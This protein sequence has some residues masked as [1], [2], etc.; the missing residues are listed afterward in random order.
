MMVSQPEEIVDQLH[1]ALVQF[2]TD[3][4][5]DPDAR[6]EMVAELEAARQRFLADLARQRQAQ[7]LWRV[8]ADLSAFRRRMEAEE[9][10]KRAKV[11]Q[12]L[13][14]RQRARTLDDEE[15]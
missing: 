4:Q 15:A 10:E 12:E 5:A 8:K 7:V 2:C 13:A 6:A 1:E 3:V 14:R 11:A 9:A